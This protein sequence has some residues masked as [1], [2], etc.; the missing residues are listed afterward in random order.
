M[1]TL[2]EGVYLVRGTAKDCIYDLHAGKLWH[3]SRD[4]GDLIRRLH[5][6]DAAS[7]TPPEREAIKP[8]LAHGLLQAGSG[9]VADISALKS[10]QR[11]DFA[12][13]EI[14][15]ACNLRCRHCYNAADAHGQ[16]MAQADFTFACDQ[17]AAYGVKT[18]ELIGG[19]PLCHPQLSTFLEI[20]AER[21][22]TV[23]LFT[24]GT[25]LDESW[26]GI[27]KR[28]HIRTAVSVYSYLPDMHDAVTQVSG[29]HAKTDAAVRML[30]ASGIPCRTA[31]VRMR[32]I[33]IG[34][35]GDTPY[36]LDTDETVRLT[37]RGNAALLSADLLRD[38][39]ICRETFQKALSPKQ[40]AAA[41]SGNPC[42]AR[43]V[44][45]AADLNVYPCVMERR[46]CHGNL[47]GKTL[48]ACLN[49]EICGWNRTYIKGCAG[50]ELRYACPVCLPDANGAAP[51]EK[52]YFCTYDPANGRWQDPEALIASV[53]QESH[54][55]N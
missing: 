30:T 23:W 39:L 7:L 35:R 31:A 5:A 10:P 14:C 6:P 36:T 32:G 49:P 15:T 46:L 18:A 51:D 27:L 44:Y 8:L 19:E 4:Y 50:C 16:Q 22:E 40:V 2:R 43:R 47:R 11:I 28:L 54:A 41:V 24:N 52:P 13:I 42:F 45:I 12:W 21:F 38:K 3:I 33:K 20:A 25:L 26:C 29:S 55:I 48:E 17:L 37:G 9:A 1:Y 34:A 53:L